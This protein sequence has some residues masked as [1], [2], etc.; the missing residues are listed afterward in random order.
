MTSLRTTLS[1]FLLLILALGTIAGGCDDRLLPPD[2]DAV[3]GKGLIVYNKMD[4][5]TNPDFDGI[6]LIDSLGVSRRTI[7][8]RSFIVAPPYKGFAVLSDSTFDGIDIVELETGAVVRNLPIA[9]GNTSHS[10]DHYSPAISPLGDRIAYSINYRDSLFDESSTRRIH[11]VKTDG[12]SPITLDIGAARETRIRFSPDGSRIA[13]FDKSEESNGWLYVARI[14]GTDVRKIADV[15]HVGGDGDMIFSWS[16]DGTEIVYSDFENGEFQIVVAAVDGSGTRLLDV[17][18]YTPDWSPDGETILYTSV[19]GAL[20]T[21]PADG[22]A[23]PVDLGINAIYSTWS[24]D[25]RKILCFEFD[26]GIDL[27]E[28]FPSLVVLDAETHARGITVERAYD[29][30]WYR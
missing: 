25:G 29:G 3:V 17:T 2:D 27:D 1:R 22:S 20:T 14:D 15:G 26:P 28:Q 16:P 10:I 7:D 30:Y 24:P 23:A 13:F 11:I 19:E 6:E 9:T 8:T 4:G 21:I 12:S 5:S 18:G